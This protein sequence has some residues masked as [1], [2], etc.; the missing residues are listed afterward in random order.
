[1]KPKPQKQSVTIRLTPE[2]V[3]QL[4]EIER[5]LRRLG[6][7][8]RLACASEIIEAL[9]RSAN[10]EDVGAMILAVGS[11]ET[12]VADAHKFGSPRLR[13]KDCTSF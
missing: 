6:M 1:M 3:D 8:P 11:S 9:I 13:M 5:G 10:I 4:A 2:A 7:R 12:V